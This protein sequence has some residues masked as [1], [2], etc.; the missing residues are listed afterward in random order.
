MKFSILIIS[1]VLFHIGKCEEDCKPDCEGIQCDV[2]FCTG[3]YVIRYDNPCAC[4]PGCY[5]ELQE[6]EE[7][8][9][10]TITTICVRGLK[11]VNNKCTP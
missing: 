10:D 2:P 11:C 4:C 1:L 8:G 7:C 5:I 3:E 6:G 9:K